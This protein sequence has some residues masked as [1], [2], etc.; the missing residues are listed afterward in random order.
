MLNRRRAG[1]RPGRGRRS[2]EAE[3]RGRIVL[4]VALAAVTA[5]VAAYL[6]FSTGTPRAAGEPSGTNP[7]TPSKG[8]THHKASGSTPATRPA[9]TPPKGSTTKATAPTASTSKAPTTKPK[10]SPPQACLTDDAKPAAFVTATDEE[11][12][13]GT[14]QE[15]ATDAATQAAAG[16]DEVRFGPGMAEGSHDH[17]DTD[18]APDRQALTTA[19]DDL[20]VEVG[21]G[22]VTDCDVTR[23]YTMT[24]PLVG[25]G[26]RSVLRFHVQGFAY[27]DKGVAARLTVRGNGRTT[28]RDFPAGTDDSFLQTVQLP[29]TPGITY[30]L[31]TVVELHQDPGI[32]TAGYLNVVT[33][34]VE[35]V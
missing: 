28:A 17:F 23:S 35:I 16:D 2:K 34:D 7:S 32:E 9:S 24:I 6:G 8:A 10:P 20:Q 31:E 25:G 15:P 5:L 33:I 19:F 18:I 27:V 29:A 3:M 22:K 13:T 14:E 30:R 26:H 12:A 4:F 1:H 11:A 21:N